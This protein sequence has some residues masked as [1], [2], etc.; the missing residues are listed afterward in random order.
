MLSIRELRDRAVIRP[1]KRAVED[2][3][4]DLPG[5]TAVDIGEK[6]TS[7]RSTGQQV[8][9]VS[10]A[11]K[12]PADRLASELQVPADILGIPTDVIEETPVLHHLHAGVDQPAPPMQR[13]T[14]RIGGV[15][16]GGGI[17]P[18][19][20]VQL[21][22]PFV[23]ATGEY[24]RIGTLGLLVT[25]NGP[26]SVTMGLTTFDVACLDDAWSVGDRMIDPDLDEVYADLARAALSGRVDAAA[27]SLGP[28]VHHRGA[29]DGIGPVGGQR[30]AYPGE[31]VRKSGYATGLTSGIVTSI[32]TTL[33]V[34][35]GDALG[36]RILREQMR[37]TTTAARFAGAGD[38]GA[39]LIDST[40]YVVGLHIAGSGDGETGFASPI[41]DVLAEL[42]VE[43]YT[44]SERLEV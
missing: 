6:R 8:I 19:R 9:V 16:A 27:V 36:V 11:N 31:V 30:G 2:Q 25:G 43:L 5:V 23:P 37:I 41:A 17:A 10:V 4:L 29:I 3:L 15:R 38:A 26:A 21:A 33:R 28:G 22:P 24:R 7:G 18:H 12:L 13:R 20:S 40:G 32:D 39:A 42:D 14:D 44:E 34:D 35:H 1:I